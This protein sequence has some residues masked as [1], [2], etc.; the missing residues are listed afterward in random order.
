MVQTEQEK[1]MTADEYKELERLLAKV[2]GSLGNRRFCIIPGYCHDGVHM[3]VYDTHGIISDQG[4][5]IDIESAV[6]DL[7]ATEYTQPNSR[8]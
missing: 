8:G 3:A 5:Y 1:S 7:A 6:K 4:V 2:F